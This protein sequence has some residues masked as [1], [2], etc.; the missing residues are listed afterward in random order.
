[1][2]VIR[3]SASSELLIQEVV[4]VKRLV[5]AVTT[6]ALL[7]GMVGC[8]PTQYNL[9][10]SSTEGGSVTAP[11]E[12]THTYDEGTVVPFVAFPHAGYYFVSWTGDVDA[13]D[14][15]SAAST[16]ITMNG[17]YSLTANFEEIP[18]DRYSLTISSTTGGSVLSPS[19]GTSTRDE[20][21]VVDL[22]ADAEEGYQFTNWTGDVAVLLPAAVSER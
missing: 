12:G 20:G 21:T 8:T 1:M 11:G 22:V 16:T 18:L 14:D 15:V 19:E 3:L 4:E 13:I 10:I 6:L 9:T 17:D 5:V 2:G 7:A